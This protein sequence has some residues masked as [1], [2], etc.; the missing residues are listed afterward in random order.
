MDNQMIE[1]LIRSATVLLALELVGRWCFR[2]ALALSSR[3]TQEPETPK[4]GDLVRTGHGLIPVPGQRPKLH[5][6]PPW[7]T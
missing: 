2:I 1:I 5:S 4:P 6:I 7:H 3:Q